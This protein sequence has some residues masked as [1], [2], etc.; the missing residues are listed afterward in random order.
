[1]GYRRRDLLV[2]DQ[3]QIPPNESE[4]RFEPVLPLLRQHAIAYVIAL[5]QSTA[6]QN[7]EREA[8]FARMRAFAD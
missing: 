6:H 4:A 5:L 3:A 2:I 8:L 7:D 1:A